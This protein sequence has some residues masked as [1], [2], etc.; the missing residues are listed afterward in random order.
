MKTV[1]PDLPLSF[2]DWATYVYSHFR[3][4]PVSLN[5]ELQPMLRPLHNLQG[6]PRPKSR[7]CIRFKRK[8]NRLDHQL[9]LRKD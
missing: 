3:E 6:E 7:S 5:H 4:L 8:Y 2:N 1:K 9:R